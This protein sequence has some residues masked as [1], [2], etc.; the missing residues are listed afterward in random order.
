M[1]ICNQMLL[2]Q[3]SRPRLQKNNLLPPL[4]DQ[5]ERMGLVQAANTELG[6]VFAAR[7]R[8]VCCLNPLKSLLIKPCLPI[9]HYSIIKKLFVSTLG[10]WNDVL[11]LV[12][13]KTPALRNFSR[14]S[15]RRVAW[16]G[17]T[18]WL[19]GFVTYGR[20]NSWRCWDNCWSQGLDSKYHD[21][22]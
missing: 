2:F 14:D 1:R 16:S 20:W 15:L 6:C 4:P 17:N 5:E 8:L 3:Q 7:R 9:S 10:F 12:R 19:A 21:L 13:T 22:G 18:R 11:H